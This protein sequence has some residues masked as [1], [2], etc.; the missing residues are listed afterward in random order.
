VIEKEV[1]F[2]LERLPI[3]A[4]HGSEVTQGYLHDKVIEVRLRKINSSC[5]ITFKGLALS[6][7]RVELEFPLFQSAFN[8]FWRHCKHRISKIR[9]R[10]V[11]AGNL[12]EIDL[13]PNGLII[14]ECEYKKSLPLCPWPGEDVTANPEFYNRNISMRLQ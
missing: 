6:G 10:I 3:E 12:W 14:A 11:T 13:Y 5:F 1:K 2:K 4:V 9:Y 8:L 7:K